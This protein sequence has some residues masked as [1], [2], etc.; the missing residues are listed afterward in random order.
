MDLQKLQMG[1]ISEWRQA[2]PSLLGIALRAARRANKTAGFEALTSMELEDIAEDAISVLME[3]IG[4]VCSVELLPAYL[5]KIARNSATSRI[6]SKAGPESVDGKCTSVD[7]LTT[8]EAVALLHSAVTLSKPAEPAQLAE[9]AEV[10]LC[11][12]A[13]LNK[14][15]DEKRKLL[16]QK[17][18]LGMKEREIAEEH[19]RG[20][21][22]VG[23]RIN[24][25]QKSA[26]K[27]ALADPAL[28]RLLNEL[29]I[30][31]DE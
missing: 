19:G 31:D 13:I 11:L 7:E 24:D 17:F 2:H 28:R 27:L 8:P 9:E 12:K 4:K 5:A 1:D 16:E 10:A 3:H 25:A 20:T 22:S 18:I 14:L 26:L 21:N 6:R 15:P 29:G 23:K 30:T